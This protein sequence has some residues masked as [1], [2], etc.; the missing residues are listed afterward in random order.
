MIQ[1]F[2]ENLNTSCID[3]AC[4]IWLITNTTDLCSG[5]VL[6]MIYFANPLT[7][8]ILNDLLELEK[9]HKNNEQCLIY[10]E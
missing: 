4:K 6:P 1:L 9:G 10:K 3:L 5:I 7:S 8:S 2:I